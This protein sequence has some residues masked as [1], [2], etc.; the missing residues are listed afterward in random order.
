MAG[1]GPTE[2]MQAKDHFPDFFIIGAPRCGTT[3]ISTYLAKN[4]NIC[5]SRPKEPHFFSIVMDEKPDAGLHGD[6]LDLFFPHCGEG[7]QARGEGS[8]SYLYYPKAIERT[9]RLS[10]HARFIV[11][12]RN[13]VDMVHSY[14]AR[15][16]A[17]PVILPGSFS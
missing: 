3:A 11:M 9:Q 15:L 16:L 8:V 17:I 12:A 6:Y 13:P 14:H 5:F 7:I 2:V 10:P 4:P 1:I